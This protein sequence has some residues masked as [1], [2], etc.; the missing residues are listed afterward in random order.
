MARFGHR[1]GL[2]IASEQAGA[3]GGGG[4]RRTD[5]TPGA[6][7]AART[8]ATKT[9]ENRQSS[10]CTELVARDADEPLGG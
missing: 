4:R 1:G 9:M 2:V 8:G 3:R 10:T 6:D 5:T 7:D